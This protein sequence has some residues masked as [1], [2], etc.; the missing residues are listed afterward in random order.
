MVYSLYKSVMILYMNT[1]FFNKYNYK[2]L[3][4]LKY[5]TYHMPSFI[6]IIC[7]MVYIKWHAYLRNRV[8]ILDAHMIN[9]YLHCVLVWW[10]VLLCVTLQTQYSVAFFALYSLLRANKYTPSNEVR[11]HFIV[12]LTKKLKVGRIGSYLEL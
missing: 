7:K 1:L 6:F 10:I 2:T 4:L 8:F 11:I 9:R 12:F 3:E 5:I